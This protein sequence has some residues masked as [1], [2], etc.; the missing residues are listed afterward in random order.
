MLKPR[1]AYQAAK[2]RGRGV[3]QLR[4]ILT[5]AIDEIFANNPDDD[6]ITKRFERFVQLFEALLA[7]HRAA[8]GR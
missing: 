6:E 8:G 1:L 5:G 2:E 7:Y 4:D 3:E